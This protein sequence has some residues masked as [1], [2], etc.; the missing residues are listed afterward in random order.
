M[1]DTKKTLVSIKNHLMKCSKCPDP[2]KEKI[3]ELEVTHEEERRAQKYGSQ[4]AF[5]S[6]IWG[7]LHDGMDKEDV[8][9]IS[10]DT[11]GN[12]AA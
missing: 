6:N 5:F 4:K 11:G 8:Q 7:R 9:H 2:I 10:V 1:A 12:I 3:N